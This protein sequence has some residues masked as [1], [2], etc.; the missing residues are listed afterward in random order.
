MSREQVVAIF[1]TL[2]SRSL[3]LLR[4]TDLAQSDSPSSNDED[5]SKT[6][7]LT[8]LEDENE[9]LEQGRGPREVEAITVEMNSPTD[10]PRQR[11]APRSR[12]SFLGLDDSLDSIDNSTSL[13]L[14]LDLVG[15]RSEETEDGEDGDEHPTSLSPVSSALTMR[16]AASGY[17]RRPSIHDTSAMDAIRQSL[18]Q[19]RLSRPTSSASI[20]SMATRKSPNPNENDDVEAKDHLNDDGEEDETDPHSKRFR[21]AIVNACLDA[22]GVI[23]VDVWLH[24]E[25][26]GSFHH[27]PGGY[28]RHESIDRRGTRRIWPWNG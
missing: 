13:G 7:T 14:D 12:G 11:P 26:D 6:V 16:S 1:M 2:D 19:G 24:D 15:G 8:P 5:T 22:F 9:D 28:Y 25:E 18:N 21:R 27:A 17:K 4:M 10:S 23:G 20:A 3:V